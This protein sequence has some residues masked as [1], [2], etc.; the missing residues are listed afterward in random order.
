MSQKNRVATR[1]KPTD[2]LSHWGKLLEN[3][4]FSPQEFYT[5]LEKALCDRKVPGL[6]VSRVDWKEGGPLSARREY[7]RLTRERLVFDVCAAPFGTGFFVSWW[8]G[9]KPLKFGL[10]ALLLCI[11]A[12]WQVGKLAQQLFEL[13]DAQTALVTGACLLGLFLLAARE[14]LADV[15]AFLM[16]IPFVG[17]VYEKYLRRITF[18]RVDLML[19]YQS[20]VHAAVLQ[21]I[22]EIMEAEGAQ[23]LPEIDRKPVFKELL[24]PQTTSA[25][26]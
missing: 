12:I 5:K 23:P 1:A 13:D 25:R 18:Y 22:D 9:R 20:A 15:D 2:I 14:I 8:F 4:S 17:Y 7:L 24:A 10:I 21:V 6:D 3:L 19:M 11:W 16:K 26:W